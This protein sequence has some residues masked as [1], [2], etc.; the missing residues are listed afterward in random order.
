MKE[1]KPDRVRI[2]AVDDEQPMLDLY[3]QV[4]SA[5]QDLQGSQL[6]MESLGAKL[7]GE[8]PPRPGTGAFDLVTCLQADD[9]VAAVRIAIEGNKPFAVAFID[10]RLPP[11]RDGVWTAEHI[12]G[13][14]PCVEIV[15]VT[16]HSDVDPRGIALRVPP[17][18]KLLY[19]QKPFHPQEMR[20][21]VSALGA[22]WK[23]ESLLR[24]ARDELELRVEE[25]TAELAKTN[26]R[27]KHEIEER[28]QAQEALRESE[29]RLRAQ[30]KGIPIPTYTWQNIEQDFILID[31]ND[32]AKE[33]TKGKIVDFLGSKLSEMYHDRP[34]VLENFRHCLTEKTSVKQES[35]FRLRSTRESKHFVI[36]YAFVPPDLILVHTQDIDDCK[37]ASEALQ[38]SEL[39]YRTLFET[40]PM[41]IGICT[42]DGEIL[43]CNDAMSQLTGYPK[44]K[45]EQMN[46]RHLYENPDAR[47]EVVKQLEDGGALRDFEV[48]L[49]H[50]DGS[51]CYAS[52]N[53]K[54]LNLCG[55]D[56]ILTL[57]M[58]GTE[59]R[60]A[61]EVILERDKE[62]EIRTA[63]LEE[64]N[65]ALRVL[66]NRRDEDKVRLE[67]KVLSNVRQLIMP[68]IEKL[69]KSP[70]RPRQA[71]YVDVL[72]SNLEEI[73]SPF[74]CTLSY[75]HLNFTPTELQISNLIKQGKST[76]DMADLLNV[77][78]RTIK[79]HRESIRK[80]LGIKHKKTNLRTYLLSLQ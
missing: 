58:D 53:M 43:A 12:R 3:Q 62:L 37:R 57:W 60:L 36:H 35:V 4:L 79:T 17:E 22:K 14:D 74:S 51:P 77:A 10:V 13:L 15:M 11:G 72:E 47:E 70:L 30:Y 46:W 76:K 33:I 69:K 25:R 75:T 23:A 49:K 54:P 18:D 21:F 63:H 19:V 1:V 59:R 26:E 48:K 24:K 31:Y 9:A 40:S 67:E 65:I 5:E 6:Q 78:V 28:A 45:L 16:A 71:A 80:K 39:R 61:Q 52:L 27:L 44:P 32:A 42:K 56:V 20:Q 29:K 2:L 38:D 66:L 41:G 55:Q 8:R 34:E 64:A 73:I 50:R 68:Y 7:F